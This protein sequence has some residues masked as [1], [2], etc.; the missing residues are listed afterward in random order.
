MFWLPLVADLTPAT[1]SDEIDGHDTCYSIMSFNLQNNPIVGDK[2][3]NLQTFGHYINRKNLHY[4][5]NISFW[6]SFRA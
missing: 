2:W 6:S 5:F 3:D 4:V 1:V